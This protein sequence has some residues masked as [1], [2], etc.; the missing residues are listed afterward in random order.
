M[1]EDEELKSLTRTPIVQCIMSYD[2]RGF[3]GSMA[4]PSLTAC[5]AALDLCVSL[6]IPVVLV[7]E[8]VQLPSASNQAEGLRLGVLYVKH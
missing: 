6:V 4:G 2:V 1:S 5:V 8:P 7:I 3:H